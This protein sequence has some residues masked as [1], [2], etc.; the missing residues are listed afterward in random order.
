MGANV[1]GHLRA[2]FGVPRGLGFGDHIWQTY[3]FGYQAYLIFPAGVADRRYLL[4][5]SGADGEYSSLSYE[6]IK[7]SYPQKEWFIAFDDSKGRTP[8]PPSNEPSKMG[9]LERL[10]ADYGLKLPGKLSR[11]M[12]DSLKAKKGFAIYSI[13][14]WLGDSADCTYLDENYQSYDAPDISRAFRKR[15]RDFPNQVIDF[16]ILPQE[17]EEIQREARARVAL[18]TKIQ[19]KKGTPPKL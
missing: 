13:E 1:L 5:V 14:N 10:L 7:H 9:T 8:P 16:P 11:E 3:T 18:K 15:V 19:P 17:I 12:L 4:N 2:N 6:T